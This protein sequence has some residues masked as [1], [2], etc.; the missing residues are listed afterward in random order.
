M[1]EL[2]REIKFRLRVEYKDVGSGTKIDFLY[3]TFDVLLCDLTILGNILSV[4]EY[5]GLRDKN[6]KEIYEGDVIAQTQVDDIL[7]DG[8]GIV[9]QPPHGEVYWD[10]GGLWNVR[11][12]KRGLVKLTGESKLREIYANGTCELN[13]DRYDGIFVGSWAKTCKVIGNIYENP[14]LM[15]APPQAPPSS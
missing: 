15:E 11:T 2:M 3:L 14:E 8:Q 4:D 10:E 7:W 1:R 12:I 5:T 13:L 6:G 9:Q